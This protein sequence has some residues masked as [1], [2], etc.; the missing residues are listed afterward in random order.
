LIT[1]ALISNLVTVL[2]KRYKVEMGELKE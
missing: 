2:V 1:D